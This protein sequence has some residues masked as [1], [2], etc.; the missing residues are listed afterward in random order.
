MFIKCAIYYEQS[1]FL[2]DKFYFDS[3]AKIYRNKL[4]IKS[5][6]LFKDFS[7]T[8]IESS[9]DFLKEQAAKSCQKKQHL[10]TP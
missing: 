1:W 10:F 4:F 7:T 8:Y 5:S 3:K 2:K 9:I 6:F